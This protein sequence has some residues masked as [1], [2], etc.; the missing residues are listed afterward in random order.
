MI[1]FISRYIWSNSERRAESD[2]ISLI[3]VLRSF[4]VAQIALTN[5]DCK[6]IFFRNSSYAFCKNMDS[7]VQSSHLGSLTN[8]IAFCSFSA[9]LFLKYPKLANSVGLNTKMA[10][11]RLPFCPVSAT[12]S[13]NPPLPPKMVSST[14]CCSTFSPFLNTMV[15]LARPVKI[16]SPITGFIRPKSP[17]YNHPYSSMALVVAPGLL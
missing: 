9:S 4:L 10:T 8:S 17:V 3:F 15:S 1:P 2:T 11:N 6:V 12:Y 5:V 13:T 14:G 7:V 16:R